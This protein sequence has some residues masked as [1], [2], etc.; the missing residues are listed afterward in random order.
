MTSANSISECGLFKHPGGKKHLDE[1]VYGVKDR[2]N[3]NADQVQELMQKGI[4]VE[5]R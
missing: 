4:L 2:K 5:K 3:G 1:L